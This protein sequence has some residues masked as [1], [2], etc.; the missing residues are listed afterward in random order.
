MTQFSV[1]ATLDRA[2]L[3]LLSDGDQRFEQQLLGLFVE[4][5]QAHILALQEA[6]ASRNCD[7]LRQSAHHIKGSSANVG[8]MPLSQLASL[9]ETYGI[10]RS[11]DRAPSVFQML[12]QEF[13]RVLALVG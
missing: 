13:E 11:L 9:L 2:A 3:R 8:A 5:M 1:Y 4:D 7:A 10:Q 6:I 12:Q